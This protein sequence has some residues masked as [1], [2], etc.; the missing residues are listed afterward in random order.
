MVT[1]NGCCTREIKT[2][3][4]MTKEAFNR[5]ISLLIKNLNI[6]HWRKLGYLIVK[7]GASHCMAQRSGH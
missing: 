7:F 2:R 4:T 1:R 5:E 3:F 6:E